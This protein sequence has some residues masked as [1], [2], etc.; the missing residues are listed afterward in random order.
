MLA[1][2]PV[3]KPMSELNK[4]PSPGEIAARIAAAAQRANAE[5]AARRAAEVPLQLPPERQS[6][7]RLRPFRLLH[8]SNDHRLPST[9][10][11]LLYQI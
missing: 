9:S 6:S 8:G 5:A 7:A 3:K 4:I 2:V 10:D 11:N 1:A